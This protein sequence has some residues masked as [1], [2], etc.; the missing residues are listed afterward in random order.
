MRTGLRT[1]VLASIA[2]IGG[3]VMSTA[4]DQKKAKS[5]HGEALE[6]VLRTQGDEINKAEGPERVKRWWADTDERTWTV[7]RTAAPGVI[8]STHSFSV[9]YNI[10]GVDVGFWRVHTD[11]NEVQGNW[12]PED[13]KKLVGP[14][15]RPAADRG[16]RR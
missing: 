7:R 13:R 3:L 6:L 14:A 8:D 2:T 1:A 4:A 12:L 11:R 10:D 15:G 5:P 16:G 9:L